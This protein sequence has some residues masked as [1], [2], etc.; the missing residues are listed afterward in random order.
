MN[1]KSDRGCETSVLLPQQYH[2]HRSLTFSFLNV[3]LWLSFIKAAT[4][5]IQEHHLEAPVLLPDNLPAEL[6]LNY[7][8]KISVGCEIVFSIPNFFGKVKGDSPCQ[9]TVF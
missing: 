6:P 1:L 4:K 9:E 7:S 3:I 5:K 2:S 8:Q